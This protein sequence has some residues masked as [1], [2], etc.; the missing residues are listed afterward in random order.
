MFRSAVNRRWLPRVRLPSPAMV[1][2]MTALLVATAGSAVA[3]HGK[4]H[5]PP[6]LVNSVDVQN[7][8]LTGADVKNK[9]LTPADFRGSVRGARGARGAAGPPGSQGS[10]GAQ[11][12]PGIQGAQGIQGPGGPPGFSALSYFQSVD[13]PNPNGFLS[14]ATLNCPSGL[15]PVGGGVSSSSN[16]YV[17]ES[18]ADRVGGNNGWHGVVGNSSGV[19]ASFRIH[20]VCAP[21]SSASGTALTAP[22]TSVTHTP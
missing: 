22:A 17:N 5:G 21:A 16:Q 7:N 12:P 19:A 2:A 8:S 3:N 10:P 11:G 14:G 6:G 4:R 20:V 13:L 18:Y 1:V 9:S 15:Y